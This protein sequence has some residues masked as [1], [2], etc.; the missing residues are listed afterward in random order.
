MRN[1]SLTNIIRDHLSS[2]DD[3]NQ[4]TNPREKANHIEKIAQEQ[5]KNRESVASIFNRELKN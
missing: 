4:Y 1:K 3:L 2:I 5:G